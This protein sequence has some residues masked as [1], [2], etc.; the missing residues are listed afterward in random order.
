MVR[1]TSRMNIAAVAQGFKGNVS[2]RGPGERGA[3]RETYGNGLNQR[4]ICWRNNIRVRPKIR[5]LISGWKYE[6]MI[7][8]EISLEISVLH[9][10]YGT[11]PKFSDVWKF[12][13]RE[14]DDVLSALRT[15]GKNR[16]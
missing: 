2:W 1:N 15:H 8:V 13:E 10:T 3:G 9:F 14:L 12:S 5:V 4:I 16:I 7:Q 11:D 6:K